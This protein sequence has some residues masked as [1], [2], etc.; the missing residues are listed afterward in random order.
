M[1]HG[2]AQQRAEAARLAREK[3]AKAEAEQ[4]KTLLRIAADHRAAQD[5]RTF[6]K[7]AMAAF[8]PDKARERAAADW[9][10]WAFLE[11]L[12]ATTLAA[13]HYLSPI[14]RMVHFTESSHPGHSAPARCAVPLRCGCPQT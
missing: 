9:A 5:I 12:L 3:A 10:A 11:Q 7:A 13:P 2:L 1:E 4:R 14:R 6:V 8:G